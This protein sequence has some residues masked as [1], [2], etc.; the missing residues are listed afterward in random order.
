MEQS[1]KCHHTNE[2]KNEQEN[3]QPET[4]RRRNEEISNRTNKHNNRRH[5]NREQHLDGQDGI[6][7]SDECPPQFQTLQH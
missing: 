4:T 2:G 7:F 6:H 1:K 5:G 3:V